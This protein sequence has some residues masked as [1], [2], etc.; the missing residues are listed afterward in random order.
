MQQIIFFFI[1]NK[2]FLLFALL[3]FISFILTVQSH[4]FH[5]SKFVS[6]ANFFSG[7]IYSIRNNVTDYFRLGDENKNLIEENMR[8]RKQL[9]GFKNG[10]ISVKIDSSLLPSRYMFSSARVINNSYSRSKNFITLNKGASDSLKADM[11]AITSKGIVGIINKTSKNYATVQSILNTN[12]QINAKLKKSN[13][14]GSLVWNTKDP[15]VVQL[16]DVPRLAPVM[17]GDTIVTGGRSTIFPKGIL[18]GIIKEFEL[19]KDDNYYDLD[20]LLFN[21]MT[22]I[23]HVYLIKNTEAEEIKELEKSVNDAE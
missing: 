19:G 9:E 17:V 15:N 22:S 3:F 12:S 20:I 6:S 23:D 21:D 4:S 18:I 10:E 1:R 11:G 8:L 13:H 2:N 5:T 16:I 7:G 14:F